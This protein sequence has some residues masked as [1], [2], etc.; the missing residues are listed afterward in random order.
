M[1]K[2]PVSAGPRRVTG[3]GE[4][5]KVGSQ[6]QGPGESGSLSSRK[7]PRSARPSWE[8]VSPDHKVPGLWLPSE[9]LPGQECLEGHAHR[10]VGTA[11]ADGLQDARLVQLLRHMSH[12]KEALDLGPER[13]SERWG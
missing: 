12:I 7:E 6:A 13:G 8:T 5:R 11:G 2:G 3:R 9:A 1:E 10:E 4:G